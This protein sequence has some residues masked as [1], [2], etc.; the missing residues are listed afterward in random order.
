[1]HWA[2]ILVD[3]GGPV[4]IKARGG[5]ISDYTEHV[6]KL[7]Q[8]GVPA[9]HI[10]VRDADTGKQDLELLGNIR[11]AT[12]MFLL[13]SG[14]VKDSDGAKVLFSAGADCVGIAQAALSDPDIFVKCG[15]YPVSL[16][17]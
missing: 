10:N 5:A 12:G 7:E 9:F 1:M 4:I 14:Y 2:K 15:A 3:A 11:K 17:G 6:K 13:A 8:I 16:K